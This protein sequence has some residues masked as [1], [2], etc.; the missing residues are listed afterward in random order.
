M[1]KKTD[2]NSSTFGYPAITLQGVFVIT[3]K[4]LFVFRIF[5][6]TNKRL[7]LLIL[8]KVELK[9]NM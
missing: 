9:K 1:K 4:K 8:S 3:R 6:A 7:S 2:M 5:T